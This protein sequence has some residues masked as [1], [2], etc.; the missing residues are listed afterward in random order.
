MKNP[1]ASLI[2]Y[3]QPKYLTGN[4]VSRRLIES[5]FGAL[6]AC[7]RRIE[8]DTPAQ[9]VAEFGCGEGVS[10]DRLR[11][12][13]P[14]AEIIGFDIHVPSVAIAAQYCAGAVFVAGDVT[15]AP[16]RSASADL[17]V[18]LEVLEHLPD[19]EAALREAA[20]VTR[21]WCIFSV[22][23]EP[24]WRALNMARG[25]YWRAWGNTPGHINHWSRRTWVALL[26]RHFEAA[27]L[28]TPLPWLMAVCRAR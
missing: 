13:L 10:T 9:T 6:S 2:Q 18:M 12:A 27:H 26:Q 11:L 22:P 8:A 5:F 15:R 17:V 24:I 23:H 14:G 19:P 7:A 20:R 25:A 1:R 16:L 4:P 3:Q 28:T 21:G